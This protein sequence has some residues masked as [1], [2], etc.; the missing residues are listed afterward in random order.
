MFF[1][2][3]DNFFYDYVMQTLKLFFPIDYLN[4]YFKAE[5]EKFD[6]TQVI[7]EATIRIMGSALNFPM[8]TNCLLQLFPRSQLHF[9]KM[10][11]VFTEYDLLHYVR[12]FG[13]RRRSDATRL[14]RVW[15]RIPPGVW[16]SVCCECC[17]LSGR[18]L[19]VGLII[20]SE[21][22]YRVWCV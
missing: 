3:V 21:D 5:V 11:Y 15:V 16:M 20:R 9:R 17:V 7:T 19:C 2:L 14:L 10:V 6:D 1:R 13:P 12:P 4:P 8:D 18:G 22:F